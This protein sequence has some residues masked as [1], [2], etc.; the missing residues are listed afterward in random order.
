VRCGSGAAPYRVRMKRDARLEIRLP[1][2]KRRELYELADE[3]GLTSSD[4]VRIGIR[5]LLQHRD[6]LLKLPA[7]HLHG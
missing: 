4:L 3:A 6:A 2:A 5:W 7:G 1:A